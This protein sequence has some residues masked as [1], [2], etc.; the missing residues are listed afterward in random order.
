MNE[1]FCK[2]DLPTFP[3]QTGR[4]KFK[5]ADGTECFI[6]SIVNAAHT[7][8]YGCFDVFF[9]LQIGKN[10]ELMLTLLNT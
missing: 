7:F 10:A 5:C 3:E 1:V 2:A 4:E 6:M 8:A 9:A